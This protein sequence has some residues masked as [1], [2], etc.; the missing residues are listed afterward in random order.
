MAVYDTAKSN[1]PSHADICQLVKTKEMEK[2]VRVQLYWLA[3]DR[4]VLF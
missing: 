1:D 2:S 3:K 4:L